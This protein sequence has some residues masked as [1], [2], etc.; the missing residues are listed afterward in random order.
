MA[1]CEKSFYLQ[2]YENL[3]KSPKIPCEKL[4]DCLQRTFG[5]S[6]KGS[7]GSYMPVF[8][9]Y[10]ILACFSQRTRSALPDR[11][12]APASVAS[13]FSGSRKDGLRGGDGG[14]YLDRLLL[15]AKEFA[16]FVRF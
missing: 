8:Q 13:C 7:D 14:K 2:I 11:C 16:T 9:F 10:K 6:K 1:L 12:G 3:K 15:F 4:R 5:M